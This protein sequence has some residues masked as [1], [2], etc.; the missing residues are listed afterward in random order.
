MT[1][2]SLAAALAAA[3]ALFQPARA[4]CVTVFR[5][6]EHVAGHGI[7]VVPLVGGSG[8]IYPFIKTLGQPVVTCGV[9]YPGGRAHAPNENLRISDLLLGAKH[10]AHF[11][12][13]L[14]D[15]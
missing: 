6:D 13:S 1:F 2:R 15:A 12:L 3:L 14:L 9:G 11:M 10:T 5:D 8:P 4:D 7:D